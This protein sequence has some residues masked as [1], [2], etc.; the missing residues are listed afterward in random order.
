MNSKKT[1]LTTQ[2]PI[3][4]RHKVTCGVCLGLEVA[5]GVR[6]RSHLV[7]HWLFGSHRAR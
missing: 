4:E 5:P 2:N 3:F 1:Q 6:V 7:C